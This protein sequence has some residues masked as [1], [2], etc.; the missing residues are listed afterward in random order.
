MHDSRVGKRYAQALF[1]AALANDVVQSVEDDLAGIANLIENDQ[2][3][4]DFVLSPYVGSEE[5]MAIADKVL[6]D[7]ITALTMTAVRLLL[8]KG[9]ENEIL[10]VREEFVILR[11]REA[12][13]L[14]VDVATAELLDQDLR[15]DLEAKLKKKFGRPVEARY[16]IEP[17]LTG[18]IRLTYESVVLDGSVRGRFR[19][20][21]D[22]LLHDVLKQ[23]AQT[24]Q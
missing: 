16:S 1:R 22:T 9:R 14:S 4:R 17:H 24:E 5:K 23:T 20:L 6:G 3:F 19:K 7:R 15:T 10:H 8:E 2:A 21:K 18:G 13:V 12:G 11:Q